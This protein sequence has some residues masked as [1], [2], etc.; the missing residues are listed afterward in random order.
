[1]SKEEY[2]DEIKEEKPGGSSRLGKEA[3]IGVT[4]IALLLIV[5]GVVVAVRLRGSNSDDKP[6][7]ATDREGDRERAGHEG[8]MEAMFKENRLEAV[9]RRRPAHGCAGEGHVGQ[10]TED[11]GRRSGPVEAGLRP[12]RSKAERWRPVAQHAAAVHA[13]SAQA[14]ADERHERHALRSAGGQRLRFGR[15]R[16]GAARRI[17]SPRVTSIRQRHRRRSARGHPTRSA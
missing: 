1:M 16:A 15:S 6:A 8:K 13:R 7:V 12:R 9:W 5:F 10:A 14:A 11:H 17:G 2:K 3:K 4:V